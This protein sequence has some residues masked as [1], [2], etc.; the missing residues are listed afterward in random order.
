MKPLT[1]PKDVVIEKLIYGG[2][3]LARLADSGVSTGN[4]VV[5]A[6]PAPSTDVAPRPPE[7]GSA[8]A[9]RGKALF[10][11][12]VLPG[13]RVRIVVEEQKKGFARG[14][15][16]QVLQSSPERIAPACPYF[17][18]CGGCQWQHIGPSAQTVAKRD[19]LLE[20]LARQG[21][22]RVAESDL[23]VQL[24]AAAPWQYRNRTRLRLSSRQQT[25]AQLAYYR[26]GS[27]Q[28]LAVEQCPISAAPIQDA[29]ARAAKLSPPPASLTELE[30]GCNDDSSAM[31][32]TL[33]KESG[34][35]GANALT[36]PELSFAQEL[37]ALAGERQASVAIQTGSHVAVVAGSGAMQYAVGN[38]RFRLS[39]G[40]FFQVNRFLV[41]EL[42]AVATAGASGGL[43]LDLFSGVGLFTL[44]LARQFERVISV[45]SNLAASQDLRHNCAPCA[46]AVDVQAADAL[47]FLRRFR[48]TPDLLLA[49][50][51][52]GG[53]DSSMIAEVLRL[54][55]RHIRLVSCDP[56]T[57][58]RDLKT[59]LADGYRL[60]QLDLFDLFPQTFHLETVARLCR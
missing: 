8:P 38:D 26:R 49:D 13:E 33:Q 1:N 51:P 44:P 32:F 45:E 48:D 15:A 37:L 6:G 16:L 21:G 30:I 18:E 14:R 40:A 46:P 52:R 57:L 35:P 27:H 29:I 22:V 43:A 42:Q 41:Q 17:G 5:E 9:G 55:P 2:D 28:P 54:Q 4:E 56:T 3:G 53:L 20:T 24:H 34:A 50:P 60:Q 25:H 19:I 47:V 10:V 31:L 23:E 12:F 36:R 7:P 39:H 59:L 11:P 58:A